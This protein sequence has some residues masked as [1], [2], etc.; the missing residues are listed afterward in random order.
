MKRAAFALLIS[1]A[2]AGCGWRHHRRFDPAHADHEVSEHIEDVLD[3][4]KATDA[5]RA[6]IMGIKNR[7]LP[8]AMALAASQQ[9]VRQ[10]VVS[11][12]ASDHPDRAR[13]HALADQQVEALRA[14][15]HKSVDGVVDA[16]DVLTPEQRAPLV[17]KMQRF[18]AR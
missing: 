7:L 2:L 11:Q 13:L 8:E 9:K 3:D 17:K 1:F 4:V 12:L 5:Q 16:H 10:E 6:Q 15:V 18:A 14:L